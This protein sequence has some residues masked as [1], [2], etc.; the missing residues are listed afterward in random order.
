[1]KHVVYEIPG[2]EA[3]VVRRDEPYR[4]TATGPLTMDVYHPSNA[5]PGRRLPAVVV[6][7]GYAP[8]TPNPL[9]CA[10]KDMAVSVCW[11]RLLAA[12]GLAAIIYANQ[13]PDADLRA[14]LQHVRERA[15][16]LGIDGDR[17]GLLATSGHGPLA[18]S[19]LMEAKRERL[20]CGALMYPL[21]LDIDGAT[22][23]AEAAAHWGFVT[24]AAG[25]T[26]ADLPPD[27]P[28]FIARTGRDEFPGLN[29]ALDRFVTESLR[30]NL[31]V[32][33]VNHAEAPHAF[34]LFHDSEA[35]REIIRQTLRFLQFQLRA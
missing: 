16:S 23:V 25:R 18:L 20:S 33:V 17:V 5:A 9:G 34:D 13:E 30:H 15:E 29:A 35:S 21:T 8:K 32:T 2:M 24:P 6:V 11:G 27:L 26:V 22:G 7:L 10:F 14:V 28:L 4:L 3:A 19:M 12:S 1:M 31:P